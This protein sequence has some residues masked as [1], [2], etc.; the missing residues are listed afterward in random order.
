MYLAGPAFFLTLSLL[1]LEG[2]VAYG[3]FSSLGCDP[4]KS[5]QIYSPNQVKQRKACVKGD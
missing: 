1:T 2:A 3:Y 4:L 5:K